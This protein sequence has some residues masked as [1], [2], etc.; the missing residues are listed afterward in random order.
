MDTFEIFISDL[1]PEVQK[2]LLDFLGLKTIEEGNFDVFSIA[3]IEK[4][5]DL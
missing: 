2:A 5:V 3:E 1:K 4:I